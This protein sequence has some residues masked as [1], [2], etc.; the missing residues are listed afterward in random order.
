MSNTE[1]SKM[2][3]PTVLPRDLVKNALL[4]AGYF[5]VSWMGKPASA[6]IVLPDRCYMGGICIEN[7]FLEKNKIAEGNTGTLYAVELMSRTW[8]ASDDSREIADT[9]QYTSYVYCSTQ[10]PTY[11]VE[12]NG[13]YRATRLNPGGEPYGFNMGMYPIYWATCHNLVGPDFFSPRMTNEARRLGYSLNL[14]ENQTEISELN[15]VL[16]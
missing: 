13:Q 16:D 10:R 3:F 12:Q 6:E 4:V 15:E 14:V 2:F 8:G 7:V 11:V 9:N 1:Q 5:L